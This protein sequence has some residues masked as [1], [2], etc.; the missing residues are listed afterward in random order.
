MDR[1]QFKQL[2]QE[3]QHSCSA[4]D[5]ITAAEIDLMFKVFDTN[6]DGAIDWRDAVRSRKDLVA[7]EM[8][9]AHKL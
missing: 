8:D 3:V 7:K 2:V 6:R 5:R 9:G 1:T 4:S